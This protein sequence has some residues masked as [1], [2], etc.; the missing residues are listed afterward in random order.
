MLLVVAGRMTIDSWRDTARAFADDWF[1]VLLTALGGFEMLMAAGA[2]PVLMVVGAVGGIA[3]IAAAWLRVGAQRRAG[4]AG[5]RRDG[6]VR[7]ARLDRGGAGAAR[8]GGRW[9][10]RFPLS[11]SSSRDRD[12]R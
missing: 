10:W 12:R 5:R 6:A 11:A 3:L 2:A 4:R 8:R 9:S 1:R 7:G